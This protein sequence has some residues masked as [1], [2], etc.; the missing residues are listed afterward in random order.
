MSSFLSY[1]YPRNPRISKQNFAAGGLPC[2]FLVVFAQQNIGAELSQARNIETITYSNFWSPNHPLSRVMART[3][4]RSANLVQSYGT[5]R[6]G[7]AASLTDLESLAKG[8][9]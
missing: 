3:I 5:S 6:T 9:P 7:F 8:G 1:L 2:L 4:S